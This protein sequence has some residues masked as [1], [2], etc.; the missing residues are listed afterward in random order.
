MFYGVRLFVLIPFVLSFLFE[1]WPDVK[2]GRL[3]TEGVSSGQLTNYISF[4]VSAQF[5]KICNVFTNSTFSSVRYF[6]NSSKSLWI[7]LMGYLS[8]LNS[9]IFDQGHPLTP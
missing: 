8:R 4:P 2:I 3:E 6:K 1:F 5:V 7:F 9:Q